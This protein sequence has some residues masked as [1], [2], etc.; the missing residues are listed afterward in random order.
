MPS[1]SLILGT[2]E[3]MGLYRSFRKENK[4]NMK[5]GKRVIGA[6]ALSL[7]L[8]CQANASTDMADGVIIGVLTYDPDDSQTVAFRNYLQDYLGEAFN[9]EFIYSGAANSPEAEA[10]FIDQLHEMGIQGVIGTFKESTM[11]LCEKYGIYYVS[12][13]AA[14]SDDLF[15]KVKDNKY[16]L[17]S[18]SAS[19]QS[20]EEE[21][22]KMADFFATQDT[23]KTQSYIICVGGAS[24]GNAMHYARTESMIETLAEA[25]GVTLPEDMNSLIKTEETVD[26]E[27][28]NGG[29]IT[30]VPGYPVVS[31]LS[32]T[33]AG[34]LDD[35]SYQVVLSTMGP[36]SVIEGIE[37]A[38][39]KNRIDIKLGVVDCF[40]DETSALFNGTY[41]NG[42]QELDY[43]VGKY[44]SMLAPAFTAMCNAYSGNAEEFREDGH[45]FQLYQNYWVASSKEEFNELYAE[46]TNIYENTYSATDIMQVLKAFNPDAD[47]ASFKAFAEK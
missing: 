13:S 28:A 27:T 23:D 24:K 11:E 39:E 47:F 26:L 34:L 21:S 18:I 44:G 20:E 38:E 6:L 17:G 16:F 9:A 35:G 8:G 1:V 33:V 25:Y 2:N 45:A 42:E 40:T 4:G 12:G 37:A 32:E 10:E 43:L 22:A 30:L 41:N 19:R 29:K 36:S 5:Y 31:P 46:T 7:L 14:L 15:E 3:I